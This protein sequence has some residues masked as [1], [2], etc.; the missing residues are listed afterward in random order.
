MDETNNAPPRNGFH[1]ELRAFSTAIEQELATREIAFP[2]VLELSLR[3]RQAANDA[4][5]TV[6]ACRG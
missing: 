4:D 1:A 2:A 3:I 5:S 6:E